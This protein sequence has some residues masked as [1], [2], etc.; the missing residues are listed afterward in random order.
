MSHDASKIETFVW[1][2]DTL[3]L[4]QEMVTEEEWRLTPEKLQS[5][6]Q[7][8]R[9]YTTD[10]KRL[11]INEFLPAIHDISIEQMVEIA[12]QLK[13]HVVAEDWGQAMD[14]LNRVLAGVWFRYQR[15]DEYK[16]KVRKYYG[17]TY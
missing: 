7:V 2:L 16:E 10:K 3:E 11:T 4:K 1:P 5:H 17:Y 9:E 14:D 15:S 8:C 6:K 13:G 12:D